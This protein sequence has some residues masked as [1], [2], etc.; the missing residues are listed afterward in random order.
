MAAANCIARPTQT[1]PAR[2][3]KTPPT[4]VRFTLAIGDSTYAVRP[5]AV[6]P[7]SGL[8]KLIR[9][10]KDDGAVHH[11][12]R[13]AHGCECDCPDF[14][15]RREGRDPRGCRH[16]RALVSVGLVEPTPAVRPAASTWP[17]WT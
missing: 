11:V 4:T 17:D 5:L 13:H 1:K 6:G 16:I 2:K 10:R 3:A 7:G 12:S 14:V 8:S 9:L 15:Y